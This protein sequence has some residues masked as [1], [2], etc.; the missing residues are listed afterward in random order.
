MSTTHHLVSGIN[1]VVDQ[2][3]SVSSVAIGVFV[4][5]GT[6]TEVREVQGVSHMLEHMAFKGTQNFDQSYDVDISIGAV[7][8]HLNAHTDLDHTAFYAHVR[9]CDAEQ[10]F[11]TLSEVVLLPALRPQ[12]F[13]KEVNVVLEEL[14]ASQDSP[15]SYVI[16]EALSNRYPESTYGAAILGTKESLNNMST[17][18]VRDYWRAGYNKGSIVISVSG[19]LSVEQA[20]ALTDRYF[21]YCPEGT[22]LPQVPAPA[23]SLGSSY[24]EREGLEQVHFVL[25]YEG[26]GHNSPSRDALGIVNYIFGGEM[27][28]HLV[29]EVREKRGL[30]YDISSLSY[31]L[32]LDHGLYCITGGCTPARWNEVLDISERMFRE[33]S[34]DGLY[35]TDFDLGRKALAGRIALS[36]ESP[37]T[38]MFS[39]GTRFLR[40]GKV[41][42]PLER[43][44]QVEQVSYYNVLDL[45]R[46]FDPESQTIHVLS[47]A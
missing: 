33:L 16:E 20:I 34:R 25:A 26:L 3:S 18:D 8:G 32:S 37:S 35:K 42:T 43:I 44:Q 29:Q 30:A 2:M 22:A 4:S 6:H 36:L 1:L 19:N 46:T 31:R 38:R 23:P 27:H 28:S 10:A 40:S 13:Q 7:G 9:D 5:A 14:A 47:A 15:E 21:G 24:T 12:D 45:C 41:Y 17:Q 39:N 11:K